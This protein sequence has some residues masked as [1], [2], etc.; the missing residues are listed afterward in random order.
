PEL[1]EEFDRVIMPLPEKAVDYISVAREALSDEGT[2]HLYVF[3]TSEVS[4]FERRFEGFQVRG[5]T[6]CGD[7][8]PAV[9]RVCLEMRVW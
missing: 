2:V 7:K 8:N 9:S 3:A 5:R 1:D 6:V 4:E